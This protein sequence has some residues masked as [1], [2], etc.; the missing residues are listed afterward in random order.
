M[1]F[2]R[3]AVAAA[4]A[5]LPSPWRPGATRVA[6]DEAIELVRE[7]WQRT[8]DEL[9]ALGPRPVPPG[10]FRMIFLGVIHAPD[11]GTALDRFV[12]FAALTTGFSRSRLVVGGGTCR[13]EIAAEPGVVVRPLAAEL[14]LALVHRFA[15]WLAARRVPLTALE[16][17]F[18]EPG[19]SAE[20]V[21]VFGVVAAFGAPVAAI[22]F[23]A[24]ELS[25]PVV[26]E[27]GDLLAYL[28]RS[29]ADLIHHRDYGTTTADRVRTIIERAQAA[30]RTQAAD[31]AARLSISPQ[32]LRRLLR[33]EGTSF[34]RIKEEVLRDLA[35]ADLRLG[36]AS[37]EEISR[38]LGFSEP[39]AFRRAFARWTGRPPGEYR[40]ALTASGP[41]ASGPTASGPTASGPTAS[42]VTASGL[43]AS[44]PRARS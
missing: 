3:E 15:A 4:E 9:L 19:H 22:E 28:C 37:V 36:G 14:M 13:I 6:C 21:S 42:G 31:V 44:G 1:Q 29:P 39:S 7:L 11:L 30:G 2:V 10:T 32:H 26:R 38:R 20:Y 8:G 18:P 34:Q 33:Q 16:L 40:A 17:S 12:Q 23:D 5:D 41:T 24:R 43:A 35:V 25:A 27:E